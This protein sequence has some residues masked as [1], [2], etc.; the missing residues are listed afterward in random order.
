MNKKFTLIELLVV[1]AII[2]I[3][4]TLL[5]PSLSRA[6]E[7]SYSVVCKNN[8]KTFHLAHYFA[9]EEGRTETPNID[10]ITGIDSNA[11]KNTKPMEIMVSHGVVGILSGELDQMGVGRKDVICPIAL[12]PKSRKERDD[13]TFVEINWSYGI[14]ATIGRAPMGAIEYP[15]AL[16]LF[17]DTRYN[18][19]QLAPSQQIDE[20]HLTRGGQANMIAIDGHVEIST[21]MKLNSKDYSTN[22]PKYLHPDVSFQY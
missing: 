15:S 8:L 5:V 21:H 13:G 20:K 14:N 19:Y 11:Y 6:R 17:G 9:I 18:G 1:I 10:P 7:V 3:L 2:G 16:L 22:S 12:M 4:I